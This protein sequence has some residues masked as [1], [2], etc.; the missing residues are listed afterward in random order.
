MTCVPVT[1]ASSP[2]RE[3]VYSHQHFPTFAEAEAI[4]EGA[5]VGG[6]AVGGAVGGDTDVGV[7]EDVGGSPPKDAQLSFARMARDGH[8]H[9]HAA[10]PAP[11]WPSLGAARRPAAVPAGQVWGPKAAG[12]R[13]SDGSMGVA[14][15]A[16]ENLGERSHYI[17]RTCSIEHPFHTA[18]N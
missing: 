10:E 16:E 12:A 15:G 6:G 4:L 13:V 9:G 18:M 8:A 7:G 5:M 3:D 17:C 1:N 2:S 14:K 11:A